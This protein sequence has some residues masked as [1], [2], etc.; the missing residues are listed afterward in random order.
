MRGGALKKHEKL[1]RFGRQNIMA[2]PYN[3]GDIFLRPSTSRRLTVLPI[4]YYIQGEPRKF[5]KI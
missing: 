3:R 4:Y 5:I 2:R 1:L